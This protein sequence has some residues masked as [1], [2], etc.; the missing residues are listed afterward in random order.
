MNFE[1]I[2]DKVVAGGGLPVCQL[3]TIFSRC[4]FEEK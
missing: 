4:R 3:A 2:R 1:A